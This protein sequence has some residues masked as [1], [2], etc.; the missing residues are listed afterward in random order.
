MQITS[1]ST[2]RSRALRHVKPMAPFKGKYAMMGMVM[3]AIYTL[4]NP[5]SNVRKYVELSVQN[6]TFSE[7]V[8]I[9]QRSLTLENGM[10]FVSKMWASGAAKLVLLAVLSKLISYHFQTKVEAREKASEAAEAA[11]KKDKKPEKKEKK[12][13]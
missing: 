3:Y 12:R 11:A 9:A 13:K 8:E 4:T 6:M 5:N 2:R 10:E 7:A 1:C